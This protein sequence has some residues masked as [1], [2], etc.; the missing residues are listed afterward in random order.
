M[1]AE[2]MTSRY[3]AVISSAKVVP[4]AIEAPAVNSHKH[5]STNVLTR[6]P[7]PLRD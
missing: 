5:W 1:P 3:Q 7:Y 6:L 4:A 2:T